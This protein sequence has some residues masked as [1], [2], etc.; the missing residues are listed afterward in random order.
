MGQSCLSNVHCHLVELLLVA[1]QLLLDFGSVWPDF[2]SGLQVSGI[3]YDH[4]LSPGEAVDVVIMI[5]FRMVVS[6]LG[7]RAAFTV[8]LALLSG[9]TPPTQCMC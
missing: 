2:L 4:F 1:K 7:P 5:V 6:L 3:L 8:V 9:E